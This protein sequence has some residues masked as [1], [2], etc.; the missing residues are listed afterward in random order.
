[1]KVA[2]H[3]LLSRFLQISVPSVPQKSSGNKGAL[4]GFAAHREH[5]RTDVWVRT[6]SVSSPPMAS[7]SSTERVVEQM[8]GSA[9]R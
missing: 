6:T 1:M 2:S 7:S 8:Q 3:K 4:H 5:G 9:V